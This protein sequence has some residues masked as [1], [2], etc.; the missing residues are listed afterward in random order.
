MFCREACTVL[1]TSAVVL[2]NN[3]YGVCVVDHASYHAVGACLPV[4]IT[5]P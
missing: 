1:A 4:Q 5:D 3:V 2:G